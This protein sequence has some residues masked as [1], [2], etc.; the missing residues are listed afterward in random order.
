MKNN[1]TTKVS[2]VFFGPANV[3]KSTIIGYMK[4][5]H[6]NK[7]S[8]AIE[9]EKIKKKLG[10]NYISDRLYSYFVDEAKDE[11]KKNIEKK[12]GITKGTSKYTHISK[13]GDFYL[14]DTPGG[15]GYE[16]QRFKGISIANIGIFAIEIKQLLNLRD[17]NHEKT[18]EKYIKTVQNFFASWYVWQKLFGDNNSIILLTKYDSFPSEEYFEE[19]KK[20]LISIIGD[21]NDIPI[22]PTS[23]DVNTESRQDVNIYTKLKSEWYKGKTLIE[24]IED[25]YNYLISID[26]IDELLLFYNRR[27]ENV[28]GV[29]PIIK[30]K[31]S[32]GTLNINDKISIVPVLVNGKYLKVNATIKSMH[33]ENNKNIERAIS[34]DIVNI[35]LSSINY[36]NTT[37]HKDKVEILNTS[38]I[39]SSNREI[40]FGNVLHASI[41]FNR[42]SK[43]ELSVLKGF[44]E[45]TQVK[46]LW[47]SKVLFPTITSLSNNDEELLIVFDLTNKLDAIPLNS[48]V[49]LPIENLPKRILLQNK[50]THENDL[51]RN[52]DCVVKKISITS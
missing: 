36:E 5:F 28:T 47:Y 34:G 12:H 46:I 20:I 42:C 52:F 7:A 30:W 43:D 13:M 3:G 19:A 2:Y 9:I 40:V 14:I 16:S 49:A 8:F 38:I 25:K 4:T 32:G 24:A 27:Y 1:N 21:N 51:S 26:L 29:G 10:N 44:K 31:V 41:A 6:F 18:F 17:D 50:L 11:Y 48:Q 33:D 45:G 15:D 37:I 39:V 22:I 23:V 35:A